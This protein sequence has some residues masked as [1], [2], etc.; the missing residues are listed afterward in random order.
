[1]GEGN[2]PSEWKVIGEGTAP[3]DNGLLGIID[4]T[5]IPDGTYLLHLMYL[6]IIP[7]NVYMKTGW[8][9]K[10]TM[11]VFQILSHLEY[12]YIQKWL[13]PELSWKFPEM[14]QGHP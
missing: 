11:Q 2:D 14:Q 12:L 10:W 9:L 3:V 1:M 5:V 8:N 7:S 6:I 4:A 13:K